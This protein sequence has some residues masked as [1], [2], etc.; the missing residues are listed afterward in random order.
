M[1]LTII[2]GN[3]GAGKTRL[4]NE[5]MRNESKRAGSL[6][7]LSFL[8]GESVEIFGEGFPKTVVFDSGTD[9]TALAKFIDGP[10][11]KYETYRGPLILTTPNVIFT[12]NFLF[13]EVI[14]RLR[15]N[16]TSP[17]NTPVQIT[18]IHLER[19]NLD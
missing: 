7:R 1:E 6:F 12:T 9:L 4:V 3:Q 11:V 14:E 18:H 15:S 5:L 13:E 8:E 16:R 19:F 2:T 10:H 17:L